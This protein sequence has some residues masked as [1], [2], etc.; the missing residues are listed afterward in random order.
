MS[1]PDPYMSGRDLAI[2][3]AIGACV[4]GVLIGI[5]F[6]LLAITS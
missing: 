5:G 6:V 3:L 2:G 4:V 1:E